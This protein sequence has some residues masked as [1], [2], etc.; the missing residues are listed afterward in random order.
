M[1]KYIYKFNGVY[2][3]GKLTNFYQTSLFWNKPG[4][5]DNN[6]P[7]N[8]Q[9]DYFWLM[10]DSSTIFFNCMLFKS[11]YFLSLLPE[12]TQDV[13]E[14]YWEFYNWPK[15]L[16]GLIAIQQKNMRLIIRRLLNFQFYENNDV[17]ITMFFATISIIKLVYNTYIPSIY[18]E[19]VFKLNR[20]VFSPV[21]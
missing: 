15:M 6:L 11:C 7:F 18:L 8:N 1:H 19:K 12:Y 21:D 17:G 9:P 14:N 16:Y 5:M 2:V 3:V 4:Y 20:L 13:W 10:V